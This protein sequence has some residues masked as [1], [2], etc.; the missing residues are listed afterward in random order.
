MCAAASSTKKSKIRRAMQQRMFMF[1]ICSLH[2][3]WWEKLWPVVKIKLIDINKSLMCDYSVAY[4]KFW[5]NEMWLLLVL[6]TGIKYYAF[7]VHLQ[8]VFV[9]VCVSVLNYQLIVHNFCWWATKII[10]LEVFNLSNNNK[11]APLIYNSIFDV[12]VINN[13]PLINKHKLP[14]VNLTVEHLIEVRKLCVC[15]VHLKIAYK[16]IHIGNSRVKML[17]KTCHF[18]SNACNWIRL[19]IRLTMRRFQS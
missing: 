12:A 9:C 6:W 17:N 5:L 4:F 7:Q 15:G 16:S 3:K 2:L 19:L 13:T 1:M 8:H 11:I 18:H 14:N 10:H